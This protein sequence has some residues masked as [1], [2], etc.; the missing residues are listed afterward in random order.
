[1]TSCL[2][3]PLVEVEAISTPFNQ[4]R[5]LLTPHSKHSSRKNY[6]HTSPSTPS[7]SRRK[8]IK[9][10]SEREVNSHFSSKKSVSIPTFHLIEERE[11]ELQEREKRLKAMKKEISA[12]R[13][14]VTMELQEVQEQ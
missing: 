4:K 3:G 14:K 5:K 7:Y 13:G 8:Q 9:S 10:S 11:K 6:V 12:H 1:M 2:P